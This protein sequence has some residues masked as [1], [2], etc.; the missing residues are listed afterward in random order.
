V[1]VEYLEQQ[2]LSACHELQ[3]AEGNVERWLQEWNM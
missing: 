2:A 1:S 3:Y